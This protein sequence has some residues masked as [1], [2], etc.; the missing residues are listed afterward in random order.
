MQ[1]LKPVSTLAVGIAIGMFV[2]PR[3]LSI[4]NR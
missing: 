4:V 2:M 1:F 3:V